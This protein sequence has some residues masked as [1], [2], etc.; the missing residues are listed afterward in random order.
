[1]VTET[2]EQRVL[3]YRR[4]AEDTRRLAARCDDPTAAA[5]YLEMAEHWEALA[6]QAAF[7][8]GAANDDLWP[9]LP[10]EAADERF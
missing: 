1:M 2:V 5:T 8:M 9:D 7:G 10:D 4:M 6:H 3:R